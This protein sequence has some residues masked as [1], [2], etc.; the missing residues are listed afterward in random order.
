MA[1]ARRGRL[2]GQCQ[3]GDGSLEGSSATHDL[4]AQGIRANML[5]CYN[6]IK[7]IDLFDKEVSFP[8]CTKENAYHKLLFG[9]CLF[10]SIISERKK[11]G[12]LG[13][14]I[15][16]EFGDIDL[17]F[18]SQWLFMFLDEQN[19]VPW[20]AL[21]YVIGQIVYGGRSVWPTPHVVLRA[22][23]QGCHEGAQ[24]DF[25]W[26]ADGAV[27]GKGAPV[28]QP[29]QRAVCGL[30]V[31]RK[32]KLRGGPRRTISEKT[33]SHDLH[34]SQRSVSRFESFCVGASRPPRP[35]C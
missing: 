31:T 26:G 20:D 21:I 12:P 8:E 18:G 13:W 7:D 30:I 35:L 25:R 14:N 27:S 16:Y 11:F 33:F 22:V 19:T 34:A 28:T 6:D 1:N 4:V 5:R 24:K 17:S 29:S 15:K 10:H 23:K 2:T 32:S 9:L 3:P